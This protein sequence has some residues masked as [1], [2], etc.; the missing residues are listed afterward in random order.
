MRRLGAE[1]RLAEVETFL[2]TGFRDAA[3]GNRGFTGT[4]HRKIVVVEYPAVAPVGWM[5]GANIT[6]SSRK[7]REGVSEFYGNA[8][9]KLKALIEDAKN[10]GV[11]L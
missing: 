4:M 7:N 3:Y 11:K 9:L 6:K 2:G 5:G 1:Q 10:T 8:V